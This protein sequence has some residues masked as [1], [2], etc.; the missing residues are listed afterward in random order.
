[1]V[2]VLAAASLFGCEGDTG[3]VGPVGA[4]GPEGPQ[5]PIG[6]P[7]PS[8]A[9]PVESADPQIIVEVQSVSVPDGGGAPTV[10]FKLSDELT[11]GLKGLPAANISF[12]ISQLSPGTA[13]ASSEWQAY[14]T[15]SSAGI[16]NAQ[17]TT[18]S[19]TS[20]T[21]VDNGD[22]TYS[23]TF[24][25]ALT[26]YAGGPTFDATKT[27][28]LGIEI[29]TN[30]GGFLPENIPAN[31]APYDFV[32][33]GGAPTF[34]RLIV[35]NDTCNAC[36]DNLEFHGEARFDVEYC[37][38]CHNPSSI[39]GDTASQPWGGSVD[40]K[41]M[42]HKIHYGENLAN[43]YF[44]QGFGGTVHDYSDIVFPQDVRN[45]STCHNESD[46]NTPQASNWRQVANRASCG[47][48]H[49]DIDWANGGHPG[50]FTFSD[51]TQC[52]DCHG[53]NAPIN[54]G[55]AQTAEAH[56]LVLQER[57]AEFEYEVV[58]VTNAAP[59]QIPEATI[60][61]INPQD[62]TAYDINDPNGPFQLSGSR[63]NLDIAWTTE[64][65][66]NVD[67]NDDLARPAADDAPFAPI[68]INFQSGAVNDGS[69]NFTKAAS[70]PIPTGIT[71]SGLAAL[72]G[73]AVVAEGTV[74][75]AAGLL[76]FPITGTSA[77]PRRSVVDIGNCNDCHQNLALHGDNRSG[78]TEVCSTCHN[79]NATDID[80]RV[81]TSE[82]VNELGTDDQSIDLKYMIHGIH[83]GQIGVCGYRNSAHPYFDVVYPGRLNNCEGCHLPD[84]YYPVDATKVLATTVDAGADR[85]TLTDDVAISPNTAVCSS[86]HTGT[87]AAEHM[88]QNG[89]DFAARK[90][91]DGTL[92]SS[93]VETCAVCHGPGG[94]ADVKEVHGVDEFKFNN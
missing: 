68:R 51:D 41:I 5:G 80:K 69:N 39:D 8:G 93:G 76:A 3:A 47:S 49:D 90:S 31:N 21:F 35:D 27:H 14:Q 33:A 83:A 82:C 38:A 94:T 34:E 2:I 60:R 87:L 66:G 70:D 24:A 12:I 36:H 62:G 18:E 61:V 88:K 59:G 15:R 42:I 37:V 64:D 11:R 6:N 9:V 22:G 63:I 26:A 58:S 74:P 52:L 89:G 86:C 53:P 67:P 44:I 91:E 75:V 13:G 32:P 25:E 40:M 10:E 85:S 30:R 23:Y 7:G 78:N 71:G 73:R 55:A 92:I 20:G 45:C 77:E 4:Q 29:R 48:C 50:G 16:P 56:R 19:G 28:R 46:T 54:G 79:P 84:T 72:E 1:L 65:I 57:A 17:A 81:A 43:G